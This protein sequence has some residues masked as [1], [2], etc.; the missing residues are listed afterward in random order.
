MEVKPTKHSAVLS[1]ISRANYGV[2]YTI[3]YDEKL[4]GTN[5]FHPDDFLWCKREL[6]WKV[7]NQMRWY[8]RKVRIK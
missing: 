6:K 3:A 4:H 1:R 7:E 5:S 8:L 2:A